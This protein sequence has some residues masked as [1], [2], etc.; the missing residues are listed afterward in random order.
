MRNSLE[1]AIAFLVHGLGLTCNIL[2]SFRSQIYAY[3][4]T[5]NNIV[6]PEFATQELSPGYNWK[7]GFSNGA[8]SDIF[9]TKPAYDPSSGSWRCK[10]LS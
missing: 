1:F 10:P 2:V 9:A 6:V 5:S 4:A 7:N 3:Q 8:Q